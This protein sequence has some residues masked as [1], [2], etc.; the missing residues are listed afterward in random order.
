MWYQPWGQV[1]NESLDSGMALYRALMAMPMAIGDAEC[2][3]S[4]DLTKIAERKRLDIKDWLQ[5]QSRKLA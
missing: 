5:E 2:L 4:D 1:T 3:T